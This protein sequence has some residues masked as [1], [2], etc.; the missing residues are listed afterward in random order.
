M[1]ALTDQLRRA[2][3]GVHAEEALKAQTLSFLAKKTRGYTARPA[4]PVRR[5][6]AAAC[7]VLLLGGTGGWA[8]LTPTS[9]VSID[10]NPSLELNVNRFDRVVSVS[11]RNEAGQALADSLD[12]TFL[13]CLS[14][15]E[16]V[17]DSQELTSYLEPDPAVTITVVGS[18]QAQRE[19]L[20]AAL[21]GAT[22]Q[23]QG[24]RCC[25]LDQEEADTAHH[26][27]LSYGK[28]AAYLELQALDPAITPEEVGGMTMHQ[29]RDRIAA[30]SG[31]G[32]TG[33]TA[34]PGTGHQGQGGGHG[35]GY[36]H[37]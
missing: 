3:D 9:A 24:T 20:L 10:V 2:L 22:A 27:G 11:A 16:Q 4:S 14:A 17:L 19:R 13:P 33:G 37:S 30:L 5:L 12:L 1:T 34:A 21:E 8:F 25:A 26:L 29:I 35:H 15:V 23:R 18:D 36:G 28:Y 6:A 31:L 32:E 7:L